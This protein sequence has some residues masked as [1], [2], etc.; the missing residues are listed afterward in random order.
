MAD[1][2]R[3]FQLEMTAAYVELMGD[4]RTAVIAL[5]LDADA[6]LRE[7][8]PVLT[9]QFRANW[10]TSVGEPNLAVQEGPGA[11]FASES[12]AALAVYPDDAWPAVYVQNNLPYANALE[13]GHS[14][15]APNGVVAV[16]VAELA[17][18]W[19]SKTL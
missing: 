10:L 12:A 14:K 15:K 19:E 6:T 5:S 11:G 9:G 13:D 4:L 3:E 8:S 17:A 2:I 1:N 16:T 18:K 7:R